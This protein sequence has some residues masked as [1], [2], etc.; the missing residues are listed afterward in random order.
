MHKAIG[1]ITCASVMAVSLYL[2]SGGDPSRTLSAQT[3]PG[4]GYG[5]VARQFLQDAREQARQ[6]NAK[7]ARRLA[8]TAASM[9]SDW[10]T[11]EESPDQFLAALDN[12]KKGQPAELNFSDMWTSKP[13][14][15]TATAKA[16]TAVKEQAKAAAPQEEADFMAEPDEEADEPAAAE[17]AGGG[18]MVKRREAQR[19][20]REARAAMKAGDFATAR[21]RALQARQLKA[22]WQLWDDRPEHVLADLDAREKTETFIADAGKPVK[23]AVDKV[24]QVDQKAV[25]A[26]EKLKQARAAMDSGN[27]EDAAALAGQAEKLNAAWAMFEDSPSLVQRDIRRLQ[28]AGAAA[29]ETFAAMEESVESDADQARVLLREARDAMA[30]GLV[31][32]ARAKAQ[33]A[34]DLNVAWNLTDDRPELVME[35]LA[36]GDGSGNSAVARRQP[37]K[38]ARN[39]LVQ[40]REA[41]AAGDHQTAAGLAE[42]AQ[43]EDA[44]WDLLD[45]RPELVLEDAQMMAQNDAGPRGRRGTR[46]ARAAVEEPDFAAISPDGSS[47]SESYR[48]GIALMRRGDR[49][50]AKAAFQAAWKNAGEL[51]AIERQQLHDFLQD[52]ATPRAV[53]LASNSSADEE[54]EMQEPAEIEEGQEPLVTEDS[55]V[56]ADAAQ[57]SD[58]QYDRLRTEVMNS[59]FRA[60]KM[61]T[62]SP[63]EALQILDN[64][65]AT[66][67]AAPLEKESLET[68]AG[69]VRRS[70]TTIREYR[71][72]QAPNLERAERNRN[73]MEEIRRETETKIRI[74]QEFA[75]LV[76]Q[77]N[78]LMKERRYAEAQLIARKAKDLNPDL[79]EATIMLEKAKLQKQIAFNEDIKDRKADS[80][81]EQLNDVEEAI[82]APG[83]DYAMPDAR[84]WE[85][86]KKRR[87]RFGRVDSR[88]RSESELQIENSLGQ[89]VSLHF[90][91]MP[92]TDVIRQIAVDHGINI[93]MKTR[94]IETEGLSVTQPVSIDVDGITLRSAL[95][96]LLEQAGGLVYSIENETLMITNRLEQE[97]KFVNVAYNVADLVIPV[98]NGNA[99]SMSQL[100]GLAPQ[101]SNAQPNGNGLYQV[102]DD[103]A[104]SI[105]GNG[106]TGSGGST[107]SKVNSAA[108]FS[109]L[110]NL[111]TT[112]VEPGSWDVDGGQGTIGQEENTLSLVIRQTT[113]VHEQIVDLLTQLRKLQDLQ[114][115]VE[116]RFISVSDRFFERIGVDFDWN[117]ND[118]LGDPAGVPAFGSRQLQF[119]GGG[120]QGGGGGGN[121]QGGDLRGNQQGQGGGGQQGQ[122]QQGGQVLFDPINRVNSPRD[123][124]NGS[125]VGMSG[126]NQFTQDYDIQ[127]RQGSFEIGV[128]DFG[129]FQPNAGIQV[130]MAILSDIEAFFFIQAAQGDSRS[131]I[132][133]APKVTMY[134]GQTASISDFTQRYLV[135]G[136]V[137]NIAPGAVGFSPLVQP[138]PDGIFLF[139]NG[140]VSADRRY[141]RLSM[142]PQFMNIIDVQT[143]T[144]VNAGGAGIGGG[145]GGFGGGGFGGGGGAG[146]GFGGLGGIGGGFGGGGA[147]GGGFGGGGGAGGQQGQQGGG[148]SGTVQLPVIA[149]ISVSTVVSV[150]DGGTVLLGGIKRLR[151]GRKMAGVPILNKIP[152]I[153]RLFKNSGVGRETESIMLMVTPRI[154][155]QEEEEELIIGTAAE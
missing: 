36:G 148:Q 99:A 52:L 154:I 80:F 137:P 150:P 106:R 119:P 138:F 142:S 51:S 134:N 50:G 59:V 107:G 97:T 13:A 53:R 91:D 63:D 85:E 54:A 28:Q 130:G 112:T 146:G 141:V 18:D 23:Q 81:L 56:L 133:F 152:Y 24:R 125:V 21:S 60:E 144:N 5:S 121:N 71:D 33:A 101:A 20:V 38:S 26:A 35:E 73:V 1:L 127:F 46:V 49:A 115:T 9:S 75:E 151:E 69:Y 65:L 153:S 48:H 77:Y 30:Q 7:E 117:V 95:N 124:F 16:S 17:T 2:F 93:T 136:Q 104:V 149:T 140:V 126:P 147:G 89:K 57:R 31:D 128:P 43:A 4:D 37:S 139:V 86:L 12:P 109:G 10:G 79:P 108:D 123:D 62:S 15:P 41:L 111:I 74:E 6:G 132:L 29:E 83:R 58:V 27:L 3:E 135:V 98:G 143:F 22:S 82:I 87:E 120:G 100:G 70:Q 105:S 113:S 39:L 44:A 8:E 68:L 64:T 55:N 47:A 72:Q 102:N 84:S 25:Q 131:N 145:G 32:E 45:D 129:G 88:D 92:L 14:K 61:K 114:V 42:E 103:L 19:L 67:E 34:A 110:I 78:Q 90:Q 155:I 94:A 96:L 40:A 122:Q 76:D 11:A 118:S 116:V 66:V